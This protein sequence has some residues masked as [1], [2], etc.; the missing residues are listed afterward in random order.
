MAIDE[1]LAERVREQLQGL[2]GLTERRMF[3]GLVFMLNGNMCV[4][5]VRESL[6]IRIGPD[7]YEALLAQ[8]HARPMDFTGKPL[9]GFIYVAPEGIAEDEDLAS[10]VECAVAYAGALP[11][12]E[13]T[14]KPRQRQTNK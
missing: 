10:W 5:L 3:G 8:P 9:R 1:G 14:P 6:M 12:K 7:N 2:Q 11:P 4:G 13:K